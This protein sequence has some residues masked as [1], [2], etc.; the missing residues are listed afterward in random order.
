MSYCGGVDMTKILSDTSICGVNFV[1]GKNYLVTGTYII[2]HQAWDCVLML[3]Q[4][5]PNIETQFRQST[6]IL[7]GVIMSLNDLAHTVWC[8]DM[9]KTTSLLLPWIVFAWIAKWFSNYI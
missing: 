7:F 8:C 5:W 4:R 2:S 6:C 3:G 9:Q 1:N